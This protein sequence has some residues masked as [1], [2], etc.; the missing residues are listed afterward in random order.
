VD[1]LLTSAWAHELEGIVR[2]RLHLAQR[3]PDQARSV[4]GPLLEAAERQGRGRSVIELLALL[5]LAH[6]AAG[7]QAGALAMVDR[8]LAKAEPEGYVRLFVDEGEPMARLLSQV[9]GE[10]RAYAERLL[11]AFPTEGKRRSLGGTEAAPAAPGPAPLVE[12]L[13]E[14]EL[15]ILR[16]MAAGLSN[17]EIGEKLYLAPGTIKGYTYSLFGKLAVHSRTQAAARA[18]E[19]GLLRLG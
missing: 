19:L 15:D 7:D 11:D 5:A 9:M 13:T 12:P 17:R 4:L 1:G 14:R 3:Q 10:N 2:A 8:A 18:R 16:L 6:Q